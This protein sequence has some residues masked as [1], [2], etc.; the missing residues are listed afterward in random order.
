MSYLE[1]LYGSQYAEL[2]QNGH[3]GEN[4]RTN[5]NLFLTAIIIMSFLCGFG[6]LML[7]LSA[8]H[9][10]ANEWL[11]NIAVSTGLTGKKMGIFVALPLLI[12]IY[13]ILN[14]SLGNEE[15]YKKYCAAYMQ[16]TNEEKESANKKTLRPLFGL[17]ILFFVIIFLSTI[18]H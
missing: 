17:I 3:S 18:I 12:I 8:L 13:F 16:A 9:F 10:P 2:V 7:I 1:A 6:V 4:G 15:Q 5:G 11:N 14:K